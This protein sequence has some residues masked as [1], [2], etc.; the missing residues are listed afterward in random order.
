MIYIFFFL[1]FYKNICQTSIILCIKEACRAQRQGHG[2]GGG[3]AFAAF[4]P[5][6]LY[7]IST[8]LTNEL[9]DSRHGATVSMR[10]NMSVNAVSNLKR[11][12]NIR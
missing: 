1:C 5:R 7:V 4:D 11:A 6:P 12:P 9:F 8:R 2:A 3:V 10:M